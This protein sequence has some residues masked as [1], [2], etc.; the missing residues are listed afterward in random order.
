[1]TS[2]Q[3]PSKPL[4][5][6]LLVEDDRG[7]ARIVQ[8]S[9]EKFARER[10]EL[11]WASTYEEG[12]AALK[13]NQ[14]DACLLDYQLGPRSGLDLLR[15]VQDLGI[16]TPIIFVTSEGSP[17]VDE[18]AMNLG[19]LD[20][21]VKF[22]MS[23]RSLERSLRYALKQHASLR[24]LRRFVTRDPLTAMLNRTE[25]VRVLEG[26]VEKA[27]TYSRSLSLVFMSIDRFEE[28][29]AQWGAEMGDR[30]VLLVAGGLK[31][32]VGEAGVLVRW[33][34]DT[35]GV[36]LP[37]KDAKAA[38][39]L[40]EAVRVRAAQSQFTVSAGVVEWRNAHADAAELVAAA[41]HALAEARAA[42]GNRVA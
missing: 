39:R 27:R 18:L 29:S 3:T 41:K 13:Q 35:F 9:F 20:Y 16:D 42:G 34:I 6:V 14:F 21:L 7:Q 36:W 10:F 19:A 24:E 1:M 17:D 15:E 32:I 8:A 4:R 2:Q 12:L 31:E 25:G 26:E 30:V 22:E 11:F 33:G 40:A 38:E 5:K 28:M 37:H 23:P